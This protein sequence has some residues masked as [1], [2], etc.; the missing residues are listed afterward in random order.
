MREDVFFPVWVYALV[1]TLSSFKDLGVI[2]VL[3]CKSCCE[4][5]E[6]ESSIQVLVVSSNEEINVFQIGEHSDVSKSVLEVIG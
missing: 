5:S 2:G 6:A 3:R 4:L 1:A